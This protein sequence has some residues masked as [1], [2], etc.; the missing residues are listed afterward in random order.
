MGI[1]SAFT[2]FYRER[3]QIRAQIVGCFGWSYSMSLAY[4]LWYQQEM[5][6]L[7][8][9][10]RVCAPHTRRNQRQLA[11]HL[12]SFVYLERNFCVSMAGILSVCAGAI[13]PPCSSFLWLPPSF[14]CFIFLT[15]THFFLSISGGICADWSS[16]R[17]AAALPFRR[18]DSGREWE[19]KTQKAMG[20]GSNDGGVCKWDMH[21]L[22][23]DTMPSWN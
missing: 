2:H 20:K 7:I 10:L 8:C 13:P 3:A 6:C 17:Q 18:A 9:M 16:L 4:F 15:L 23:L 12:E 5:S 1:Q 21:R 22:T 11:W 19:E 14:S